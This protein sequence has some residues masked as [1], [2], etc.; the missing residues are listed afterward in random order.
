MSKKKALILD[1]VM[2]SKGRG[3]FASPVKISFGEHKRVC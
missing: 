2:F 1:T 3:D